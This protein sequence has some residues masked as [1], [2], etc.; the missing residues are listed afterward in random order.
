VCVCVF[1]HFW[2]NE[3]TGEHMQ[4]PLVVLRGAKV[5]LFMYIY[6]LFVYIYILLSVCVCMFLFFSFLEEC[7]G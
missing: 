1:S 6:Y 3:K 5:V 2:R 7:S 4:G